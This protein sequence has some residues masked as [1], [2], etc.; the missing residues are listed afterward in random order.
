MVH[1]LT[2]LLCVAL[3]FAVARP[4]AAADTRLADA[5]QN[6]DVETAR[7]LLNAHIDVNAPEK[8]RG[9][10]ALMW[11]AEQKHLDVARTLIEHGANVNARSKSGFTPLLFAA[12]ADDLK[13]ADMLVAAGADVGAATSAPAALGPP[14]G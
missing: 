10:T 4:A 3:I 12:Q 6:R 11:A 5:V 9:Q 13:M 1:R 2:R 14:P 8:R 7:S